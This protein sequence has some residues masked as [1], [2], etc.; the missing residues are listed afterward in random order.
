MIRTLV[1]SDGNSRDHTAATETLFGSSS[2]PSRIWNPRRVNSNDNSAFLRDLNA[3]RPR[4]FTA[5][6]W[7]NAWAYVRNV[8]CCATCDPSRNH[9]LWDRAAVNS[10]DNRPN[11][12][13]PPDCC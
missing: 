13:L 6:D 9:A 8:C 1:G 2:R 4:P 7:S 5:N 11:D 3:G 10:F 12:G